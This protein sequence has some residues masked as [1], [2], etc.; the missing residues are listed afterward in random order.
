[1]NRTIKAWICGIAL[2]VLVFLIM[3]GLQVM[4]GEVLCGELILCTIGGFV[5]ASL[6]VFVIVAIVYAMVNWVMEGEDE[7]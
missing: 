6:F 4:S 1:M 5:I 3:V 7:L 2:Y